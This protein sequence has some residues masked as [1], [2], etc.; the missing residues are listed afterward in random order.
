[1]AIRMIHM[2]VSHAIISAIA[3][4]VISSTIIA[5]IVKM[6]P[7]VSTRIA[8]IMVGFR[9]IEMVMIGISNVYPEV[10]SATVCIDRTI[11]IIRLQETVILRI[12]QHPAQVV[13]T[14]IQIIIIII[15]CPF[16]SVYHII[17]QITDGID[18]I[19]IDLIDIIVLSCAQVQFIRHLVCQET[20]FFTNP[21]IT[22]CGHAHTA[23]GSYPDG[24]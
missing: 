2:F 16:V 9:E 17:H 13:I 12:V 15:Q 24:K 11:E 4:M 20:R 23:H 10:P 5:Y 3:I 8:A 7:V 1:M 21:A 18:K 19:E 22:H 6:R 14:Y